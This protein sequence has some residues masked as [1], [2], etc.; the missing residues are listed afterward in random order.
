[1]TTVA[2]RIPEELVAQIDE[3]VAEGR[4]RNRTDAFRTAVE[5]LVRARAERVLDEAIVAGYLAAPQDDAD[6]S[7]ARESL[8]ALLDEESW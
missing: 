6:E 5:A 1:M 8:R 3:L 2:F 4:F 7:A